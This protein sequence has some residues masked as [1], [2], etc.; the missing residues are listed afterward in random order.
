MTTGTLKSE[1]AQAGEEHGWHWPADPDL[2]YTAQAGEE[3]GHWRADHLK[4]MAQVGEE[5]GHWCADLL[6]E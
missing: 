1:M 3:H 6:T 2:K 5:H 4:Y